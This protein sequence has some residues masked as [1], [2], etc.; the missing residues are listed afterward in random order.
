I[1]RAGSRICSLSFAAGK[2]PSTRGQSKCILPPYYPAAPTHRGGR[3]RPSSHP[4]PD[5]GF[6]LTNIIPRRGPLRSL[7]RLKKFGWGGRGG[8]AEVLSSIPTGQ[9]LGII[10]V[11]K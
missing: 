9:T 4:L 10:P 3:F 2:S 11:P 7:G 1:S 8:L 6:A 5:A